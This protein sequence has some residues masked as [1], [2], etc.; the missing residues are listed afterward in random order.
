MKFV[1]VIEYETTQEEEMSRL[2]DE[3]MMATEGRRTVTR[4]FHT[5]DRERPT[6]YVDIVEFPSYE[7]AM[8]NNELPETQKIAEEFRRLCESEPRF[9]NLEVIDEE[10]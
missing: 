6:H 3:W 4:E 9:M 1:Q 7:Q 8:K 10:P 5:R 2:F